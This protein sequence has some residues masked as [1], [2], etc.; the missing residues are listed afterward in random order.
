MRKKRMPL[1]LLQK[2]MTSIPLSQILNLKKKKQTKILFS[3][4]KMELKSLIIVK[5]IDNFNAHFI[6]YLTLKLAY[7]K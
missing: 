6:K 2:K 1:V 4:R 7:K 3:L 5:S